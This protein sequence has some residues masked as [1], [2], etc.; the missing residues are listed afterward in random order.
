MSTT[1]DDD[2]VLIG[3][4]DVSNYNP[5]HVLPES[6]ET[7]Q[8]IRAW[9][10]PTAYAEN[11][12]EYSKHLASLAEGTGDWVTCSDAYTHWLGDEEQGLLWIKGVPGAGK[13]VL[14]AKITRDLSVQNPGTPVLYFFFRQIIDANHEPVALL[15]D[16][17]DQILEYSPPLQKRLKDYVTSGRPIASVSVQDLWKDLRAA[18]TGLHGKV[19]CV[20][21][22]LDEMDAGHDAFLQALSQLLSWKPGK[23]KVLITSRPVP[24]VEIPLRLSKGLHVRLQHDLVDGDISRYVQ[25]RLQT[26]DMTPEDQRVIREAIPGRANG[27]F[28]Y[29]KLAMD[30][31]LEAGANVGEVLESLPSDMK[32]MYA[33]LLGEHSRRT[34]IQDNVQLLIL[35]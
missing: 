12:S 2:A 26:F 20:A 32:A 9:L 13:S 1:S 16:W 17:L 30:S 5:S 28:L 31:F 22:A 3:R 11:G 6:P 7:I 14:A 19:F 27:L 10:G 29:A 33:E 8:G 4:D 25:A 23:V 18:V 21:D 15:K 24:A 34:G 35:Q